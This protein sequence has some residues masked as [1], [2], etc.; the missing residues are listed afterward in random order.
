MISK[1]KL[2]HT[3]LKAVIDNGYSPDLSILSEVFNTG[4]EEIKKALQI[5]EESEV[6]FG[7]VIGGILEKF[8]FYYT[9][10]N[11]VQVL[12]LEISLETMQIVMRRASEIKE[13]IFKCG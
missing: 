12:P 1:S 5:K 6:V 3:I 7:M 8:A 4:K 2:H 11:N 10:T 9:V 13:A